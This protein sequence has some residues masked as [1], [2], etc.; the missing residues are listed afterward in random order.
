VQGLERAQWATADLAYRRRALARVHGF[1]ERFPRAYREDADLGLRLAAAGYRIVT[2]TRSS[3]HPV[4]PADRWVSVRLQRGNADDALMRALHGPMWRA[5]AGVP[6]G[7]RARHLVVA[8]AGAASALALL[9]GRKRIAAALAG[10]WAAGTA[11]FAWSRIAPGPRSADEVMTMALTSAAI[12]FAAT[13]HWAS[14]WLRVVRLAC[15]GRLRHATSSGLRTAR[16]RPPRAVL[17]D[18]DG[19]LIVDVPYNGDP[20]RVQ[21]VHGAREALERLRAAGIPTGVVSNQ[22]GVA[23]GLITLQDVE[24]VNRR[25]DA[26][27]GPMGQWWVCPHAPDDACGCRKPAP[28]LVR[29]AAEALGVRAEE[30]AVIGDTAADVGAA[31]AAGARGVLVPNAVTRA[32]EIEA[33]QEVAPDL[34]TAVDRLLN[35]RCP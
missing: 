22:S 11:E 15:R 27:L 8:A 14:G 5:K 24:A 9:G 20:D 25:V 13:W 23:R 35:G 18:R 10:A 21:A 28:G 4:R 19:T 34:L 32:E 12:P 26:L 17:F 33:A 30:C 7:R 3:L 31:R 2:G 29:R 16:H 6:N 1:D